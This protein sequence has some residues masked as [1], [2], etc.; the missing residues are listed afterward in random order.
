MRYILEDDVPGMGV[1]AQQIF[2]I[3]YWCKEG[4]TLIIELMLISLSYNA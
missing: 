2:P 4:P 3:L 1:T